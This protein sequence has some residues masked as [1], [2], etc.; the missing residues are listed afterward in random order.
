MAIPQIHL[1]LA[2]MSCLFML[3]WDLN[4][5][6]HAVTADTTNEDSFPAQTCYFSLQ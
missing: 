4:S 5:G 6:P 3:Y 1:I 2:S